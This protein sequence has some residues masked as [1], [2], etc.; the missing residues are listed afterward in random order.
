MAAELHKLVTKEEPRSTNTWKELTYWCKR[1]GGPKVQ[2]KQEGWPIYSH[3]ISLFLPPASE[4][5]EG[6]VL[7]FLE[8]A[9][10]KLDNFQLAPF[11]FQFRIIW[12]MEVDLYRKSAASVASFMKDIHNAL[13]RT[14][15][16]HNTEVGS[17]VQDQCPSLVFFTSDTNYFQ[18]SKS[19]V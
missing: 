1:K 19:A 7:S 17:T 4:T 16:P 14:S 12:V 2:K 6:C 9:T 8:N 3:K 5:K 10:R 11:R 18:W 15:R 13:N